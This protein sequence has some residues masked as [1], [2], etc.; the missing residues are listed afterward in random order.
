MA[1]CG[2]YVP[3]SEFVYYP[4]KKLFT[5]ILNQDNIFKGLSTFANEMTELRNILHNANENSLVLGDELC[6][7]T[8]HESALSIFVSGLSY[9]Y[10]KN[11]QFLFATHLHEI[12]DYDEVGKMERLQKYH[13]TVHYN[14]EKDVL[15]YD[16]KLKPGSG[17]PIYGLEVCQ[18]LH[19][20]NDFIKYAYDIRNKYHP[21]QISVLDSQTSHFNTKK[22]VAYCELCKTEKA[23]EV[24]HMVHQKHADSKGFI[25]NDIHKNHIHKNHKSNL[26]SLCEECHNKIHKEK[27][28][29]HRKKTT[30][31]YILE[32]VESDKFVSLL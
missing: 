30:N 32:Q 10:E 16:R 17:I 14:R 23:K 20:P 27:L 11:V 5:R 25:N 3:C 13:L 4:Y 22:V 15:V 26:A 28:E 12:V 8:E 18:S 1:Q 9:L 2:M 29:L 7:G 31:G 24:H 19:L 21:S 6:S